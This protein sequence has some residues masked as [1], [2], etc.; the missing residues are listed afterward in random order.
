MKDVGISIGYLAV[1]KSSSDALMAR[2]QELNLSTNH[3]GQSTSKC[4]SN[5]D[6]EFENI[7]KNAKSITDVRLAMGF[8]KHN[9]GTTKKLYELFIY[10]RQN[11]TS[12]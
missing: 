9:G 5:S 11:A 8:L 12:C 1:A 2:I 6:A 3:W 10:S 4:F 7:V